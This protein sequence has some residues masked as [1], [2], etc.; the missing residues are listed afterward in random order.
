MFALPVPFFARRDHIYSNSWVT[1][2]IANY[3]ISTAGTLSTTLQNGAPFGIG[4]T[5]TASQGNKNTFIYQVGTNSWVQQAN[6]VGG[7]LSW[8]GCVTLYD[9]SVLVAGAYQDAG[10]MSQNTYRYFPANNTWVQC[11]NY[12]GSVSAFVGGAAMATLADG[13]AILCGGAN[14]S[15]AHNTTFIFDGTVSFPTGSWSQVTNCPMLGM[16]YTSGV[17]LPNGSAMFVGGNASNSFTS[18]TCTNQAW[19]YRYGL[20]TWVQVAGYPQ[21]G[22]IMFNNM[23]LLRDSTVL[24]LGGGNSSIDYNANSTSNVIN[25]YNYKSNLWSPANQSIYTTGRDSFGVSLLP[26][27]SAV[28]FCS[29]NLVS[30]CVNTAWT[31]K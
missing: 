26:N 24:S 28:V 10:V 11:A 16:N 5:I 18:G 29:E 7:N 14:Q 4:G 6:Y 19:V 27:G 25:I 9:G 31:F 3:P 13:K 20:G 23:L 17:S 2:G 8:G 21:T 15:A 12:A 30:N 22:G 1:S